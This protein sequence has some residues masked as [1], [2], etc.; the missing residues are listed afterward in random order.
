MGESMKKRFLVFQ[1]VSWERPGKHLTRAAKKCEARLDVIEVWHQ[2]IPDT[3]P[4]DGPIVLGGTPNVDQEKEYPFLREEKKA[5]D[6]SIE[7]NKPYLGFCLGHQLL[8]D[9]LG[10]GV[11][12]NSRNSVG[13]IQGRVTE[14]GRHHPI[15]NGI[16]EPFPLFKW[17][18]Q[19][20]LQPLPEHM[21]VLVT[22][23]DCRVEAISVKS[24]PHIIGFQS[25]NHAAT[26]EN[27]A[28]WIKSDE[29]WLSEDL[30]VDTVDM[31][32]SAERLE[33]KIGEQ[34]EVIFRNYIKLI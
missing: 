26:P 34:F 29:E 8:A 21:E 28:S 14:K 4:F 15:L 17:H 16:S 11:G 13:F 33:E 18:S 10:A 6:K 25:D 20:V 1:H 5:I 7:A 23:A 32:N 30:P 19:A 3:N 12:P 9:A 31:L 24:R 2:P 27:V 22:S